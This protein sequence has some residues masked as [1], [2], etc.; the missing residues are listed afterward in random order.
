MSTITTIGLDLAK[1][2]F[3]VHGVNKQGK[4]VLKKKLSRESVLSFFANLPPCLVGMEACGGS[5]HWAREIVK[6]GHTV[7]QISPQFV[8]PY[9]KSNKNDANDA[10]AICEAVSRPSMRFV[11]TK[12]IEQQDIQ[13]LHRIR[14]RLVGNR[15][16][17][18]NQTRGLLLELGVAIPQGIRHLRTMLPQ[19]IED[20]E[21]NQ[22]LLERDYL[23]DLY[24]ELVELDEKVASYDAKLSV[25][26]KQ[27][28]ECR[29]LLKV[30]GIGPLSATAIVAAVGQAKDFKNGRE[31]SAWL[32]LVPS[33]HSS[34]GKTKL[35]GISKRGDTYL[36]TLLIHGAR[37]VTYHHRTKEDDKGQ[38][39]R[40]VCA[41]R[42][43]N[44]AVVAQANKT[45]RIA[46]V[47]LAKGEEYRKAA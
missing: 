28:E 8:K 46:W 16:A 12:S 44:R 36:R 9:V 21:N 22:T 27:S 37:T 19:I 14:S 41:R 42:G 40:G 34:G 25:I 30:P 5:H 38:W 10:E 35:Q 32:G 15:T 17:L 13:A 4:V 2:Y 33:Q 26:C 43:I 11:P 24:S 39:I 18:A 29:R 6:F 23:S 7:K 3:Q 45:A 1:R 31:L 47:I 20:M